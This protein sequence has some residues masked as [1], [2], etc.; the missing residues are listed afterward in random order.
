MRM[1]LCSPARYR[2]AAV[3]AALIVLSILPGHAATLFTDTFESGTALQWTPI[4]GVWATCQ[5]PGVVGYRYCQTD[6]NY[7]PP[8]SFAGDD[9]W[10]DYYVQATV[11]MDNDASGRVGVLG[12]VQDKY[13]FYELRLEKD[14]VG[15]KKWWIYKN[16]VNTHT[17][18]ASGPF[19]Y[20][21]ATDYTLRLTLTGTTLA[22]AMSFD[23]GV[24]FQALGR[25]TDSQYR[26]GKVGL[27]TKSTAAAFDAIKVNT[28]G[29]TTANTRRF[30][31][32]VLVTL[33][34]HSES[35]VMGSPYLPYF[36]F[37]A[38]TYA[39]ARNFWANVHPSAPNYFAWTTGKFFFQQT[40]IPAGTN[41]VVK[42]L[43]S[44]GKSWGAYFDEP[45]TATNVFQYLP[46]VAS[47]PAQLAKVVPIAPNF[48]RAYTTNTLP[49]YVMVHANETSNGHA[50]RDTL[51]CLVTTDLWLEN[52]IQPYID[53]PG[54]TAN[55]DLLIVAWDESTLLDHSCSAGPTTILLHA[56]VAKAGAWTCG[57]HTVFLVIGSDVK[58]GYVST[59]IYHDE[60]ILRLMLEGLGVTTNLPG[61]ASF[62]AD[63]NEF[64]K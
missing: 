40:P 34:N 5:P 39:V 43:L 14:S 35:Q 12:R 17:A 63:M 16:V 25:A 36:N 55:H 58:R 19:A 2:Y 20:Q 59:K 27:K 47:S 51:P 45:K 22:A 41:N 24:T 46:E 60:S 13:H 54:F 15:T 7:L 30:G 9:G 10:G 11:N 52:T 23:K 57:G 31:H 64:F 1:A 50:C 28:A 32:I 4:S 26:V 8:L 6:P 18:L 61:A 49:K 42:R 56:D 48:A 3:V 38:S 33:E 44:S 37:L 62:A 29:S 53:S 21:R